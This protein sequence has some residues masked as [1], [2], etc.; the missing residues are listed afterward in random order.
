MPRILLGHAL[1]LPPS[2]DIHTSFWFSQEGDTG[3]V[4]ITAFAA[5]AL[6]DVVF[7]DLPSVGDTF[8]AG[9]DLKPL[10]KS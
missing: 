5:K 1:S 6:G 4:G 2:L 9:W 8:E 7:V 3:T 10:S